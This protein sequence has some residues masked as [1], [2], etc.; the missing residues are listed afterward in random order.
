MLT[1]AVFNSG[2]R[3]FRA[4]G[5]AWRPDR[6]V[7]YFI[8]DSAVP[9]LVIDVSA[10]YETKRRAL[11]CHASQFNRPS[12]DGVLTRLNTPRFQQLIESRDAQFGAVAG[13]AFAEGIVVKDPIVIEHLL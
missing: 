12:A 7:Y 3:R 13:V 2:L 8:N 11:A 6:I 10:Q 4:A 1:E 9:S 5:D